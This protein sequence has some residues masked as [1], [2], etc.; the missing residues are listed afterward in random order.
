MSGAR[1]GPVQWRPGQASLSGFVERPEGT[2]APTPFIFARVDR[3]D[4]EW[5]CGC[6]LQHARGRRR[7]LS[8][9]SDTADRQ[10]GTSGFRSPNPGGGIGY[11]IVVIAVGGGSATVLMFSARTF[12]RGLVQGDSKFASGSGLIGCHLTQNQH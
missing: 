2:S 11:C 12:E 1:G 8:P 9:I 6:Q 5:G 10:R 4:S 3:A 7:N